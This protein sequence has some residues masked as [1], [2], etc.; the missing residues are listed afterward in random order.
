MS[1]WG[2]KK[3]YNEKYTDKEKWIKQSII[4]KNVIYEYEDKLITYNVA[5]FASDVLTLVFSYFLKI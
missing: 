4:K 1:R 3:L 5:Y 2:E